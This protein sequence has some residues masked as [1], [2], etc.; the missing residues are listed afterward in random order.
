MIAV[1][2][3]LKPVVSGALCGYA[4][5]R[6]VDWGVTLF[7]C[8]CFV[9]RTGL[10]SVALPTKPLVRTDGV[11]WR[12]K[13]GKRCFDPVLSFDDLTA[14]RLFSDAAVSAIGLCDP[15]LFRVSETESAGGNRHER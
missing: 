9:S 5:L 8:G 13:C 4:D 3:K 1:C 7:G 2:L 11:I 15:E 12:D 14:L 6:V 10:A